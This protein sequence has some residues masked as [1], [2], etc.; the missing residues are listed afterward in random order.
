M[1]IATTKQDKGLKEENASEIQLTG[2][3]KHYMIEDYRKN[4]LLLYLD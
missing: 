4:S 3:K 1:E 2:Q